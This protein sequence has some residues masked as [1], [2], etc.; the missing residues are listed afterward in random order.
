MLVIVVMLLVVYVKRDQWKQKPPLTI[1][2]KATLSSLKITNGSYTSLVYVM[3]INAIGDRDQLYPIHGQD[4]IGTPY[5]ILYNIPVVV[6]LI[7]LIATLPSS[8]LARQ[9]YT[10]F[11]NINDYHYYCLALSTIGVIV[12]LLNHA[13]YMIIAYFTDA[14]Y[15]TG[16]LMLHIVIILSLFTLLEFTFDSLLR[17]KY[18]GVRSN[19]FLYCKHSCGYSMLIVILL[20][21]YLG[22]VYIVLLFLIEIPIKPVFVVIGSFA[23]YKIVSNRKRLWKSKLNIDVKHTRLH[24]EECQVQDESRA[25]IHQDAEEQP[26]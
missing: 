3:D 11:D 10:N 9:F 18:H 17:K 15:A 12:S 24:S 7:D 14:Y 26:L 21:S 25:D 16:V 5:N 2:S 22:L 20:L 13:P 8:L 6:L 19:I 4:I 23:V 1:S